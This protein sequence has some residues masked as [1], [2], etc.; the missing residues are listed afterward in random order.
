MKASFSMSRSQTSSSIF[1]EQAIG[2]PSCERRSHIRNTTRMQDR[3]MQI[4]QSTGRF[5]WLLL[6]H[7]RLLDTA[8]WMM[9]KQDVLLRLT[10]DM[11]NAAC[12]NRTRRSFW[13]A[14]RCIIVLDNVP[15][16]C[17]RRVYH[18]AG[19]DCA[20]RV[21][22]QIAQHL[23]SLCIFRYSISRL[24]HRAVRDHQHEKN[25]GRRY[26]L[27]LAAV[28]RYH[29]DRKSSS[30]LFPIDFDFPWLHKPEPS[31]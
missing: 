8:G 18:C 4:F 6:Q 27:S 31:T 14:W 1:L 12:C 24:S 19:V 10:D 22:W 28:N 5:T 11:R 30:M 13:I 23:H 21:E 20:V 17:L 25:L 2:I 7:V 16:E 3:M 26:T 29:L 9:I 15:T